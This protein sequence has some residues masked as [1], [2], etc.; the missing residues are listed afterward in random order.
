MT[1]TSIITLV[2]C[3]IAGVILGGCATGKALP[4]QIPQTM[5]AACDL[6]VKSRPDVVKAREYAKAHWSELT[7]E[8]QEVMRRVDA[9]L[10]E[11]DRVGQMICAGSTAL[12][13]VPKDGKKIDWD[14][15]LTT[16][17]KVG[18]VALDLHQKGV[19]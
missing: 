5:K 1:G 7:P 10:P 13:I 9:L 12:E 4:E 11:L 16:L 17:L 19:I 3:L 6:Y 15:A 18:S 8:I 2:L 14:T